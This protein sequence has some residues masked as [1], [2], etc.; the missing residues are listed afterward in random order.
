MGPEWCLLGS[1]GHV[2]TAWLRDV[3]VNTER[4]TR[5]IVTISVP[6]SMSGLASAECPRA[7][8]GSQSKCETDSQRKPSN[9]SWFVGKDG[10]AIF[11]K[12]ISSEVSSFLCPVVDDDEGFGGNLTGIWN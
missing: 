12:E 6:P 7:L 3:A 2:H 1:L 4:Y 11:I 10:A 8:I 9:A 5:P